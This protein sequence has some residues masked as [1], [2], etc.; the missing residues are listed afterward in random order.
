MPKDQ[1]KEAEWVTKVQLVE[2][3]GLG[4]VQFKEAEGWPSFI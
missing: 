1:L 2:E 3:K 4:K